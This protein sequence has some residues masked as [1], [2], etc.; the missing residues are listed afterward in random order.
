METVMK[1]I[2]P[3][4]IQISSYLRQQ[5]HPVSTPC[6][7]RGNCGKCRITVVEGELPVTTMD[8]IWLT[9]EELQNGVRLA[10]QAMPEKEITIAVAALADCAAAPA[11]YEK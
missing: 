9:E 6:G 11:T 7:G 10:C 4:G 2:C 8:K 5:G 1:H 3:P